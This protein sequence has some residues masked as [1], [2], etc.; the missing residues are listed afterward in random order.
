MFR[1]LHLNSLEPFVHL[2]EGSVALAILIGHSHLGVLDHS[3][4]VKDYPET[5]LRVQ[6]AVWYCNM[7]VSLCH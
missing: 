3:V 1:L 7:S 2:R 4:Q 6:G 5:L